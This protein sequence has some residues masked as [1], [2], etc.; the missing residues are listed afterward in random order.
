VL[1]DQYEYTAGLG[2]GGSV[3][4][5]SPA[6]AINLPANT[7]NGVYQLLFVVN[8]DRWSVARAGECHRPAGGRG[9]DQ[10]ERDGALGRQLA[11][12]GVNTTLPSTSITVN[13]LGGFA[14]PAGTVVNLF[15]SA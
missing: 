7:P 9:R 1:L 2:A 8:G 13:N 10:R 3:T 15:L 12:L 11:N 5:P 14:I 4:L 6:H